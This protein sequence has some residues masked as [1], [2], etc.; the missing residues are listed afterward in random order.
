MDG[1]EI[2]FALPYPIYDKSTEGQIL[3]KL[4][5]MPIREGRKTVG[6]GDLIVRWHVVFSHPTK[7][8]TFKK[9]LRIKV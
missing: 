8:D 4:A 5:G 7:W 6:R 9:V 1:E 2:I 3:V